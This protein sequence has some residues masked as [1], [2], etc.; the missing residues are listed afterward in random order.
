MREFTEEAAML[1]GFRIGGHRGVIVVLCCLNALLLCRIAPAAA[2]GASCSAPQRPMQQIELTFGR[3]IGGRVG[4]GEAAWSGFLA[5][6]ITP[7][8]P[9]GLTVLSATGQWRDKQR[10]RLVRE[11]SRLVILI[12]AADDT[13]APDKIAAIVAGYKQQFRQ[14]SVGVISSQ[15]CAAF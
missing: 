13:S 12:V 8:F 6:Q 3:N 7:R 5:R 10:G 4:V 11:P 14:Q 9:D 15:V 1:R 2:Q